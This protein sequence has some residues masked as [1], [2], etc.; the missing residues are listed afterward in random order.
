MNLIIYNIFAQPEEGICYLLL[1][2]TRKLWY[3]GLSEETKVSL[4]ES[5]T[6]RRQG[7]LSVLRNVYEQDLG[8]PIDLLARTTRFLLKQRSYKEFESVSKPESSSVKATS[9]PE[10]ALFGSLDT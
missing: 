6:K 4:Q 9:S 2:M 10:L 5:I 3:S 8:G 1:Q 7:K